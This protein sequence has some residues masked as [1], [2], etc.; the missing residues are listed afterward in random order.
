M[1][2]SKAIFSKLIKEFKLQELFNELGCV[3]LDR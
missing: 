3:S 1:S 2:I